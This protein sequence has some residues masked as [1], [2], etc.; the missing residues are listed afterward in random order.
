[1]NTELRETHYNVNLLCVIYLQIAT[2]SFLQPSR[3]FSNVTV[4]VFLEVA[5][6]LATKYWWLLQYAAIHPLT[7]SI[8]RIKKI[9]NKIFRL[10]MIALNRKLQWVYLGTKYVRSHPCLDFEFITCN[11]NTW[12]R[13]PFTS[14]HSMKDREN[15]LRFLFNHADS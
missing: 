5:C 2:F 12:V 3:V 10:V 6:D 9:K 11:Q 15:I 4:D 13:I 7:W 1:V 14:L 8:S